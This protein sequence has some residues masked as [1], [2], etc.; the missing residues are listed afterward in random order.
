[1]NRNKRKNTTNR[2]TQTNK[3][4]V[5]MVRILNYTKYNDKNSNRNNTCKIRMILGMRIV[6]NI[7]S[8]NHACNN[9]ATRLVTK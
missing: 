6:V 2:N 1:M 5:V 7:S 4:V 3:S 8:S 9:G